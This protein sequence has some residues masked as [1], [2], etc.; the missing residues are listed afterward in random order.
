MKLHEFQLRTSGK[1]AHNIR[2]IQK[3]K[4]N[5][6]PCLGFEWETL[7]LLNTYRYAVHFHI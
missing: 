7:F 4:P 2:C 5:S 1:A 3:T 6:N